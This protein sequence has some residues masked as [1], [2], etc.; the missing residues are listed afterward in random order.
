MKLRI[1]LLI[2]ATA[3][4]SAA[5]QEVRLEQLDLSAVKTLAPPMGY[6]AKAAQSVA[7]K[8]LT[9][10]GAVYA[11]GVGPHSGSTM[12]ID[13][14]GQAGK[15]SAKAGVDDV[16]MPLA[17]A[18]PGSAVSRG[19]ERH[20]GTATVE[21]WLDGKRVADTG[22]LR[23]GGEPK[24]ITADLRGA[25]RVTIIV[26]DAG[27]WPYNNPLDLA[28]AVIVMQPGAKPLE[29]GTL[30]VGLFNRGIERALVTAKWSDLGLSGRQPVRDLWQRKNLDDVDSAFCA[31]VPSHG[32][33]LIKVG[34]VSK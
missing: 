10:K 29:D 4:P 18:L 22:P 19:L 32:V 17:R 30:A 9:M 5:Q 27:R 31:T 20:P 23:R 12:G 13:L 8:P 25:K 33:V 3:L 6:P 1:T 24:A 16:P 26:T 14:N 34:K 28:D 2:L 11:H 7:A 15:F 21:I